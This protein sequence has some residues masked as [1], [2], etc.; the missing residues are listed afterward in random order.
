MK[1]KVIEVKADGTM[2]GDLGALEDMKAFDV[3]DK[4]KFNK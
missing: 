1:V 4:I 3:S 2:S